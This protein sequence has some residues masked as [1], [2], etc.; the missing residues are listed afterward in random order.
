[1]IMDNSALN[2]ELLK[3]SNIAIQ[4]INK[5]LND[6]INAWNNSRNNRPSSLNNINE[7]PFEQLFTLID[8]N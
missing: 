6:M 1:M 2:N 5:Y 4:N 7:L 3:A 8:S